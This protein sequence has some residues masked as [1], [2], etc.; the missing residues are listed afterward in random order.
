MEQ[1]SKA[2]RTKQFI[3]EK[4]ATLINKQGMAGTSISDIMAATKLAKGG[5]YG[6]F[7]NKDE[8]CAASFSHL[9]AVIAAGLDMAVAAGATAR[10]QLSNLLD[11]Y[12]NGKAPE[13]GCPMLNFGVESDDRY[14]AI[15]AQVR[16]AILNTQKRIAR[17]VKEGI[18]R[19]EISPALDSRAFGIKTF[20]MIEGS[21]LCSKVL[22]DKEQMAVVFSGIKKE[23]ESYLL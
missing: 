15:N 23:F 13:G 21:I 8:I 19:R 18:A 3:I 17:I 6:N 2:E 9:A 22:G 20:S 7:E 14:P 4:S 12:L 1:R 5:I 16:L 10:E 11:Y